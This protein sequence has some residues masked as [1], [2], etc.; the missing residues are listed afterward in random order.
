MSRSPVTRRLHV[1]HSLDV[2][3][4]DAPITI[5]LQRTPSTD[6]PGEGDVIHVPAALMLAARGRCSCSECTDGFVRMLARTRLRAV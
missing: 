6:W 2:I 1:T 4:N 3:T 5:P